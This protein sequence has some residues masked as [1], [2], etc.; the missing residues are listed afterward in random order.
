MLEPILFSPFDL[1]HPADR[2]HDSAHKL[3]SCTVAY[4]HTSQV[5]SHQEL[6]QI[7]AL[8][9][10]A[11]ETYFSRDLVTHLVCANLPDTKLKQLSSN[12][13]W[14]GAGAGPNRDQGWGRKRGQTGAGASGGGGERGRGQG[15][16]ERGQVVLGRKTIETAAGSGA[17]GRVVG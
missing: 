9:G 16:V 14:G 6:K 17:K 2:P 7:M 10:G 3:P 13:R 1:P 5:P 8:H 15:R 12:P 11:F 4:T